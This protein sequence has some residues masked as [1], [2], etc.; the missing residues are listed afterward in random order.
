M[1]VKQGDIAIV[2]GNCRIK[3]RMVE[4]LTLMPFDEPVMAPDGS[5]HTVET[6]EPV[7]WLC[8]VL[9][10]TVKLENHNPFIGHGWLPYAG[11]ADVLLRPLRDPDACLDTKTEK[12]LPV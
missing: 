9:D 6:G 11:I 8:R 7:C 3:G 1:N 10:G 4:V 5:C 2:I 12:E